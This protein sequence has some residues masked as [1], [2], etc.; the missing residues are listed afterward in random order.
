M[1]KKGKQTAKINFT[2]FRFM[3]WKEINHMLDFY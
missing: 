2:N 1:K 3:P